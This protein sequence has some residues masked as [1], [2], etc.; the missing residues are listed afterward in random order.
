VS[1]RR[2]GNREFIWNGLNYHMLTVN[3]FD[4][5]DRMAVNDDQ[6]KIGV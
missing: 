5:G 2:M 4:V 3:S 6:P 1:E